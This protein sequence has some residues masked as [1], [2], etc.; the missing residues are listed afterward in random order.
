MSREPA[1]QSARQEAA[2]SH[3]ETLEVE[4]RQTDRT[5]R[6]ALSGVLDRAGVQRLVGKVAPCLAG[7]GWRVILDGSRLV[8]LDFRATES[9]LQWNRHL[10]RYS[11]Q[12]FLHCWSDY[13]KAILVMEDWESELVDP[14]GSQAV[15]RSLARAQGGVLP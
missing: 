4:V 3:L 6:V 11:H 13:L 1:R 14:A 2:G 7:C 9:L 10:G 8:H 5:V 15:L 12:L